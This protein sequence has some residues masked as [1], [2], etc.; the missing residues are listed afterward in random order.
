M[1]F[2]HK[3]VSDFDLPDWVKRKVAHVWET[4]WNI[5]KLCTLWKLTAKH[6]TGIRHRHTSPWKVTFRDDEFRQ[7]IRVST[8][9]SPYWSPTLAPRWWI[10]WSAGEAGEVQVDP[11]EWVF[12]CPPGDDGDEYSV[13]Y[14]LDEYQSSRLS[15]SNHKPSLPCSDLF[16]YWQITSVKSLRP[17]G[18]SEWLR[19]LNKEVSV[20]SS[21]LDSLS[22]ERFLHCKLFLHLNTADHAKPIIYIINRET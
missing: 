8:I 18:I 17:T 22:K 20:D 9:A 12:L 14:S 16:D 11:N 7:S 19:I 5:L 2:D 21:L 10:W 6:K 13:I 4:G 1:A 15:V 3:K